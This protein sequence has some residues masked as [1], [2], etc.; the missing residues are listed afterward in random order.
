MSMLQAAIVL[1]GDIKLSH[2][3]FAMPFALLAMVLAAAHG[4]RWPS[5]GEIAL[6]VLCMVLARTA[7]MTAN[8]LFDADIDAQ[9]PR[10][11]QRAIPAG[12]LSKAMASTLLLATSLAF[13][14]AAAGFYWAARN[15]W[16][17]LASPFVLAWLVGYSL[18]KRYTWACHLW[19]GAALAMSPLAATLAIEPAWLTSAPVYFLALMVSGWVAGFDMIY[20][21][22]DVSID[23]KLKLFSIPARLGV[24]RA[25]WISRGLH[26]LAFVSLVLFWKTS[27]LLGSG[28][29]IGIVL[30]GGL[31]VL[32][33]MLMA[34]S[35]KHHLNTAFFTINGIIS[36]LL[37]LLGL[38]DRWMAG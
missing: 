29:A 14:I 28:T 6:V 22:Q 19:L 36:L 26:A 32:E 20:S 7:A 12:R 4:Q 38:W 35:P 21:L 2:T 37:G 1:A 25:L 16:P 13:I 9:N 33:H 11:A 10:T 15:P 30:V 23:R 27:P 5:L 8:R 18:T 24:P 3:L 31:L 34:R 17:M